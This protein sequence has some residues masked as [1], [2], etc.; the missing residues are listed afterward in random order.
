MA[1]GDDVNKSGKPINGYGLTGSRS[2]ESIIDSFN[3]DLSTLTGEQLAKYNKMRATASDYKDLNEQL[4]WAQKHKNIPEHGVTYGEIEDYSAGVAQLKEKLK[5]QAQ[6]YG[7]LRVSSRQTAVNSLRSKLDVYTGEAA[8]RTRVNA[9]AGS[10]ETFRSAYTSDTNYFGSERALG[11]HSSKLEEIKDQINIEKGRDLPS[12]TELSNLMSSQKTHEQGIA[13][14]ETRQKI[15]KSQGADP[16]SILSLGAQNVEAARRQGLISEGFEKSGDSGY[17]LKELDEKISGV[18]DSLGQLQENIEN[19][20]GAYEDNVEAMHSFNKELSDLKDIKKGVEAGGGDDKWRRR[21]G[22]GLSIASMG[23]DAFRIAHVDQEITQTNM[24][25]QY[26]NMVNRQ[27]EQ[28]RSALGG[29]MFALMELTRDEGFA[30]KMAQGLGNTAHTAKGGAVALNALGFVADTWGLI[31]GNTNSQDVTAAAQRS[32]NA[33]VDAAAQLKHLPRAEAEITGREAAMGLSKA[34]GYIGDKGLQSYMDISQ[35]AYASGIGGAA[36][37]QLFANIKKGDFAALDSAGMTAQRAVDL[38]S[39]FAS[40]IGSGEETFDLATKAGTAVQK[41]MLNDASQYYSLV[42][43][44]QQAGGGSASVE[45]I[46]SRAVETGMNNAK[47][48]NEMVVATKSLAADTATTKGG[49]SIAK[50]SSEILTSSIQGLQQFGVNEELASGAALA[51][52]S[53]LNQ[54]STQRGGLK[55]FRDI[56]TLQDVYGAKANMYASDILSNLSMTELQAIKRGDKE[57]IS[58]LQQKGMGSFLGVRTDK[59]G[60]AVWEA[61]AEEKFKEYQFKRTLHTLQDSTV[62]LANPKVA[63]KVAR[64]LHG[65]KD[66]VMNDEEK[67]IA[68]GMTDSLGIALEGFKKGDKT[69]NNKPSKDAEAITKQMQ[70]AAKFQNRE[71]KSAIDAVNK[72][73]GGL[74]GVVEGMKFIYEKSDPA[75]KQKE[76]ADAAANMQQPSVVFSGAVGNFKTYVDEL[77]THLDKIA[78]TRPSTPSPVDDLGKAS[79][80][81]GTGRER[82]PPSDKEYYGP[83]NNN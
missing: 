67:Q 40:T 81:K 27:Y 62:G 66:V 82:K 57:M 51:G 35:G 61:G 53:D 48:L 18:N 76:A 29:D 32:L 30:R 55:E 10:T 23:V 41:G 11:E 68:T 77:R 31:T 74:E 79:A 42:G 58:R 28:S 39:Q 6:A 75:T 78:G 13:L 7:S 37:N 64:S 72:Y 43:Q 5:H 24:R 50:T 80:E 20:V 2:G 8:T 26:A 12:R 3:R 1:N 54:R 19:N 33:G 4:I 14:H 22:A 60:N 63:Y 25:A 69:E 44:M 71:L 46:M 52:I 34:V 65:D 21:I 15:L 73:A 17:T 36:R 56:A 59:E 47:N 83:Y 49:F 45:T 70:L 9:Y 16:A 38:R